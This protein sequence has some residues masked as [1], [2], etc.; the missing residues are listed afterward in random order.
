MEKALTRN[1]LFLGFAG[2]A[3]IGFGIVV[4]VWP[5]LSLAALLA[6]FGALALL[7]GMLGLGV[8]LNLLAHRSTDWVPYILSGLGGI[9]IGAVTFF[10]PG[11]TAL[12]MVF[13]IAAWAIFTGIFEIVAAI[14]LDGEVK[15]E[16]WLVLAG[17]LSVLFGVLIAVVPIA[18]VFAILWLIG[19]YAIV[20]GAIRIVAAFRLAGFSAK[21][22]NLEPRGMG[23][24]SGRPAS[25]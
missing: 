21:L 25:A 18:G 13:F 24:T 4:L 10:R 8:G 23:S 19:L 17:V 11:I 22:R 1:A 14:E 2:L 5:G 12:V 16:W 20:T 9:A 6:L 15:G 7:V 3:A